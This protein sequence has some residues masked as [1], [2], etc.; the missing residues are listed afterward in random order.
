MLFTDSVTG[1]LIDPQICNQ[2]L[3]VSIDPQSLI[4]TSAINP[5]TSQFYGVQGENNYDSFNFDASI[6]FAPLFAWDSYIKTAQANIVTI[7][8]R[9]YIEGLYTF[10]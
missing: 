4:T 2:R 6:G 10:K 8:V 3:V 7:Q 1:A 5:A 9:Y